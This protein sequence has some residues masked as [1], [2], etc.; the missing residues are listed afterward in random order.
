LLAERR[1]FFPPGEL[2]EEVRRAVERATGAGE[3]ID[4]LCFVP[5]GEPTLDENLGRV[6][7][8]LRPLKIDVAVITNGSLLFREDVRKE[9]S[10][11][12]W[13][14]VKV[15]AVRE[16]VWRVVNRPH[17]R[18]ALDRVLGGVRRFAEEYR[19]RLVTETMLVRGRNDDPDALEEL[20]RFLAGIGPAVAYLGVPTRPPAQAGVHG[21][22]EATLTRAWLTLD[23]R[24]DRVELLTGY[25]GDDFSST[26]SVVED[27]LAIT[28]VHPMREQAVRA[29]LERRGADASVVRALLE[30]GELV[31]TEHDG[32][33]YYVRGA[34]R[35]A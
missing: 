18:L 9:L 32:H 25:E 4:Y 27:I 10:D 24:L 22:D 28:A 31:E 3:R 5:D 26:G 6:I 30:A 14:S 15:D 1:A 35:S 20:A 34:G 2:A 7:H 8:L 29:L 33:A 19:G 16:D 17:R 21:P 13:V 23:R 11:A 12:D